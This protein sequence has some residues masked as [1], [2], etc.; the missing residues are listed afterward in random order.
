MF[1]F[2]IMFNEQI[3]I[4]YNMCSDISKL[5]Y[6]QRMIRE[7]RFG[8]IQTLHY[9]DSILNFGKNVRQN[10]CD[11]K[12]FGSGS[13]IIVKKLCKIWKHVEV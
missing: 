10:L 11:K 2:L 4:T 12:Y 7:S 9:P 6:K 8:T 1:R 13:E 3:N 5:L